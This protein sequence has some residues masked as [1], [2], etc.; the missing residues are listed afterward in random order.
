MT[1]LSNCTNC[2]SEERLQGLVYTY[3]VFAIEGVILATSNL[4]I[5]GAIVCHKVMRMK[6]QY[7]IIAGECKNIL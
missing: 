5:F 4:T 7:I 1:F 6:K 2:L 3:S